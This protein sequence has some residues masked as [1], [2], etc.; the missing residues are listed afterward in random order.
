MYIRCR[1]KVYFAQALAKEQ[2]KPVRQQIKD[3][4]CCMNL[5]LAFRSNFRETYLPTIR[6]T[7][8]QQQKQDQK[9]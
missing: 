1:V 2:E 5:Y 7:A 8:H 3:A 6:L 9:I 4:N